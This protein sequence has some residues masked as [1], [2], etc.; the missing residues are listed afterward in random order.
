MRP[1]ARKSLGQHFLTDANYCHKIVQFAEIGTGDTIVEIGPGTG[2]LT[3][4]LI[5]IAHRVIAVEFDRAMVAHLEDRYPKAR[6]PNLQVVQADILTFNWTQLP[7]GPLKVVGNL[8]YNIATRIIRRMI[9]MRNRFQDSTIMVQKE[10]AE[11][12][13]ARPGSK[14]YG[15]FTVLAQYHFHRLAGFDVPPGVFTP[16]PKVNSHVLKLIPRKIPS[17]VSNYK[18][19]DALL[20][21]S[22]QQ[23]R[24]TLWNNLKGSYDPESIRRAFDVCGIEL[25]ARPQ[26]IS[27]EQYISL[28]RML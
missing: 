16:R 10:V 13:L 24:K 8:P 27:L 19:F 18:R 21:Q 12:I 4:A 9:E 11:R 28:A 14:D 25:S 6:E 7:T 3:A 26:T 15:Y 1:Q 2:Q 17:N 20:K 22:F 5:E 23:R